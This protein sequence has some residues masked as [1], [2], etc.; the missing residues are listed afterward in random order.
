MSFCCFRQ[1]P[2][3]HAEERTATVSGRPGGDRAGGLV[4]QVGAGRYRKLVGQRPLSR[5]VSQAGRHEKP[6]QSGSRDSVIT[7]AAT[8]VL[9]NGKH[10][11]KQRF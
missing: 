2:G 10:E 3:C 1:D 8:M 5:E 11:G 9:L 7:E 6:K 4:T